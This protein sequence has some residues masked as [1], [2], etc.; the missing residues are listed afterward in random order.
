M[1]LS[2]LPSITSRPKKRLGRG[3]GSGKGGHTSSRG[4]KGQ[5]SRSKI[6]LWFE[7]GQLPL[8]RRTPFLRGKGRFKPLK[9]QP[10]TI[11]LVQLNNFKAGA[12]VNIKTTTKVLKLNPA[13]VAK[14]GLKI[15]ATGKLDK[16]LKVELPASAGAIKAI[17][18]AGGE[19][20]QS[21]E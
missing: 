1:L 5:K 21:Q 16:A 14:H 13:K 7:G 4:Q 8:I 9:A 20:L 18:K 10:L 11:N 15:I 17:E 19:V 3:Y 12:K 2:N 6:P